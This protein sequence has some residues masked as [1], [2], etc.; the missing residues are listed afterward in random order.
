MNPV[1]PPSGQIGASG[2]V[3]RSAQPLRLETAH[4]AGRGNGSLDRPVADHPAHRRIVTQPVG[5]VHILVAGE[6]SEH[7][8]PQQADQSVAAVPARARIGEHVAAGVGQAQRVIQLAIRQQP[9]VG[10]DHTATELEHQTAVEIE[11]RRTPPASPVR[12]P[13]VAL[14]VPPASY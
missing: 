9:G 14:F 2:E 3:L 7:R 11:P 6:R 8:L 12:S 10:G 13:I 1:D 4:L 5:V